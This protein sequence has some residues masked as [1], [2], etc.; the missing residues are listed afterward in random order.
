MKS[1]R[2]TDRRAM[3]YSQL[4]VWTSTNINYTKLDVERSTK[5]LKLS[6]TQIFLPLLPEQSGRN[7]PVFYSLDRLLRSNLATD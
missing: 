2:A 6:A 1:T 7:T 5:S 4:S 3:I